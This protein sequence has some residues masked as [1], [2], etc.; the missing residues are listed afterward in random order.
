[1]IQ[2]IRNTLRKTGFYLSDNI[3]TRGMSFDIIGRRDQTLLLIKVFQNVD[4]FT[5]ANADELKLIA[6]AL[7]GSPIIIGHRSGGGRLE[8]GVIYS[9]FG[10][11][12]ISK[13]TF[14][15][16][17]EEGVPPY[18][19]SA[20]GGLYV[21]LDEELLGKLRQHRNVSLGTL[22]E[23]AGVSRRTVQMYLDGMSA[24]ID[25]ALRLEEFFGEPLVIPVNPFS[26]SK[27]IEQILTSWGA[28]DP[29]EKH[30]FNKLKRLGY[31]V[32]PTV[33]CPFEALTTD[34]NT[35]FLTGIRARNENVEEKV[36]I[37][38]SIS[39]VTERDSVI[40][41]E[42]QG[43]RVSIRGTP[44]IGKEELK[45][46]KEREEIQDLIKERKK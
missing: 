11:P 40:F 42:K 35:L 46:I 34:I 15:D 36:A 26:Y 22:A 21:R 25:I 28:L 31:D 3:N 16:Y 7:R 43:I 27:E 37:V 8:E 12:I 39:K 20:P 13:E 33:K 30:V 44:L 14:V 19:F 32:L 5:K 23:V 6:N 29:F 17:F 2:E 10:V 41:V 4:A 38:S 18:V 1:M 45:K 9:R 24:T